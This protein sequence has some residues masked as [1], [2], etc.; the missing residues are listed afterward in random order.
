MGYHDKS[1][2][3]LCFLVKPFAIISL[4]TAFSVLALMQTADQAHAAPTFIGSS[5]IFEVSQEGRFR[6]SAPA[7][8]RDK[9]AKRFYDYRSASSH[10]GFE[11]AGRSIVFLYRDVR[12]DDLALFLTHG[13][14]DMGQPRSQRQGNARVN[15]SVVGVPAGARIAE[16]D[17]GPHEFDWGSAPNAAPGTANGPPIAIGKW[18]YGNNTDGG[19]I[20]L[21]PPDQ[22]WRIE[23]NINLVHGMDDWSYF[24]ADGTRQ[25]L[26]PSLPLI[27]E[28]RGGSQ[29]PDQVASVEGQEVTVCALASDDTGSALS[30]R[31]SWRDG[32]QSNVSLPSGQL[33]C[34]QHT[35]LDDGH[36]EIGIRVTNNR[37]QSA[38]KV[39]TADIANVV[40]TLI[41]GGPYIVDE[42][43]PLTLQLDS[44]LDPGALDTHQTRWDFDGDG[45][46]DTPFRDGLS[47]QAIY[48]TPGRYFARVQARDD[49]GGV[50]SEVIT[51]YAGVPA[52]VFALETNPNIVI[53]GYSPTNPNVPMPVYRGAPITLKAILRNTKLCDSYQV[54]WD[55]DED[56]LF[57]ENGDDQVLNDLRPEF[58]S[59]YDAGVTYQVPLDAAEGRRLIAMRARNNCND[60]VDYDV[61]RL[62]VYPW[63]P[64]P[65][66]LLWTKEQ[67]EVM[68]Q[69][70]LQ[71]ALWFMHRHQGNRGGG[72]A[73]IYSRLEANNTTRSDPATAL[74]IWAYTINGRLPAYPPNTIEV[75]PTGIGHSLPQ[76][77]EEE[78]LIRWRLDPYSETV[79]R[80]LNYIVSTSAGEVN[81]TSEDEDNTCELSGVRCERLSSSRPGKGAYINGGNNSSYNHGVSTGAIGT[82]LPAL[83]GTPVQVGPHRGQLWEGLV[84]DMVDYLGYLQIPNGCGRGG[85]YYNR[86]TDTGCGAM[87]A[88]T[89][90]WG[91]IGLE[92]AEVAGFR[93][94]VFV[95]TRHKYRTAH[96]VVRNQK[97]NGAASYRTDGSWSGN[98]LQ[99]TGGHFVIARWLGF[100]RF[101]DAPDPQSAP[102]SSVGVSYTK[103]QMASMLTK[104]RDFTANRW[105]STSAGDYH[106]Q[107]RFWRNGDYLC[108]RATG[109]YRWGTD[110]ACGNLYG[111]YSHQKGYRTTFKEYDR[112]LGVVQEGPAEGKIGSYDW[113]RQFATYV[114]RSQLRD[115]GDYGQFGRIDDSGSGTSISWDYG[116]YNLGVT[117]GTLVLTPTIFKPRPVADG[118]VTP[119]QVLEGCSGPDA[120][121]V[122][123]EHAGSFHPNPKSKIERFQWDVDLADR[124]WWDGAGAGPRY[125]VERIYESESAE[126][127]DGFKKIFRHK[128]ERA[129]EYVVTLRVED[130]ENQAHLKNF[131]VNV[132]A[133]QPV[134]PTVNHRGPYLLTEGQA[135][136]LNGVANDLNYDC[137][138]T[139]N[140]SWSIDGGGAPVPRELRDAISALNKASLTEAE[141]LPASLLAGLRPEHSYTLTLRAEDSTGRVAT[142][143]TELIIYPREPVAALSATPLRA[144]CDQVVRFDASESAHPHP[145]IEIE[146]YEWDLDGLPGYE[147]QGALSSVDLSYPRFGTYPARVKVSATNQEE[148]VSSTIEVVVDQGNQAPVASLPE[149]EVVVLLGDGLRVNGA[150]SYDPDSGCGDEIVA[151]RWYV[152]PSDEQS[153]PQF[154]TL[155]GALELSAS[156]VSALL[157]GPADPRTGEPANRLVLEVEDSLGLKSR[158]ELRVT[159]YRKEPVAHFDQLPSPAPINDESGEVVVKLDARESF[160]PRPGGAVINYRWDTNGDGV[161][162][163]FVGQSVLTFR[164]LFEPAPTPDN[165]PTVEVGVQV[166]DERG[167]VGEYRALL[168]YKVGAVEP[169]A[170]ADPSDA[171][172]Q[173][174]H[175]LFGDSLSLNGAQS[176]EPNDGDWIRYY[177]WWVNSTPGPRGGDWQLEELDENGDAL[178]AVVLVPPEQLAEWGVDSVGVYPIHFEAEDSTFLTARDETTL[179]VHEA[180]PVPLI[181][182]PRSQLS[183]G[184][185]VALDGG[186]SAHAHP[187]IDIIRWEWDLDGDGEFGGPEDAEGER[188]VLTAGRFTFLEPLRVSLRVTDS[189]GHQAVD[190]VFLSV[191]QGNSAPVADAGGP[192]AV[193]LQD[194]LI[195]LDATRTVDLEASCGDAI[196]RY[197]WDLDGDGLY[198]AS[199]LELRLSG[200]SAP[201][202]TKEELQSLL[203]PS[204]PLGLYEVG[205]EVEDRW[206]LTARS[207]V[208]LSVFHGPTAVATAE[209]PRATCDT[210]VR[211]SALSSSSDGPLDRGFRITRYEWDFDQDGEIDSTEPVTIYRVG[212]GGADVEARLWVYDEA[213][214]VSDARVTFE[215]SAENNVPPVADAG[216]PYSTGALNAAQMM[217]ITLDGRAS[218]D[219]DAPCDAIVTYK[220]DTDND[221]LFG[222]DDTNGAGSRAGSDYEGAVIQGFVDPTWEIG[223]SKLVRLIVCDSKGACSPPVA[224]EVTVLSS[225]PP[226]GE[227]LSPRSQQCQALE[228]S[229]PIRLRYRDPNGGIVRTRVFIDDVEVLYQALSAPQD[230]SDVEQVISVDISDLPDGR[231][232]LRVELS[233]LQGALTALSPGGPVVF[234]RE[235]PHIELNARLL[236]GA[237]Y[238]PHQVPDPAPVVIDNLD[239]TPST[240]VSLSDEACVKTMTVTATDE[241]GNRAELQ[242]SYRVAGPV[243]LVIEGP[244]EGGLISQ[245]EARLSWTYPGPQSCVNSVVSRLSVAGGPA[246]IY[247]AGTLIEDSGEVLLSLDAQDCA[248]ESYLS[249]RSFR[250]NSPPIAIPITLGHPNAVP[251]EQVPTYRVSEGSPLI[252]NAGDSRAPESQDRVN[253]Y[254]WDLDGDGLFE[255]DG[256][257][258][259]L[260][261]DTSEDGHF[262]GTL[263]VE[264][265][266]GARHQAR[267]DVKVDD[268][269]PVLSLGG[270]YQGLQGQE[271]IFD[272]SESR[273]HNASD[274]LSGA[275][276]DWGDGQQSEGLVATHRFEHDGLYEV[277]LTVR[278]EDSAQ[279]AF[280]QVSVADVRPII[281][282]VTSPAEAYTLEDLSFVVEASP[283]ASGDQIVSYDWDFMGSGHFEAFP[284]PEA[285][286][287]YPEPGQYRPRLR[288]RDQD[289][290]TEHELEIN[291]R[292]VTLSDLLRELEREIT[293]SLNDPNLSPSARAALAPQGQLS[294]LEWVARGLWAEEQRVEALSVGVEGG[295]QP[296]DPRLGIATLNERLATLY[297][298]N[299]L[300]AFDELLF[301]LNRAQAAGARYGGLMWKLS[302]ELLRATEGLYSE[303]LA[304]LS[305]LPEVIAELDPRLIAASTQLEHARSIFENVDFLDRVTGRDGY[306]ARDLLAALLEAHFLLRDVSDISYQADEFYLVSTGGAAFRVERGKLV[307]Q[308]L[309]VAVEQLQAELE[310]YIAAAQASGGP[311]LEAVE[312]ALVALSDIHAWVSQPIGLRCLNEDPEAEEC[313]WI[314]DRDSLSLQLALMDL[315]GDLFAAANEGVYVRNAQQMLILGVK[316]RVEVALLRIEALCGVTSPY[317]ISARAQQSVMLTLLGEGQRDAA[318]LYYIA[319]ERRCLVYQL[320]NECVVPVLN[321][322]ANTPEELRESVEYPPLCDSVELVGQTSGAGGVVSLEPPIPPRPPFTELQLLREIIEAFLRPLNVASTQVREAHYPGRSWADFNRYYSDNAFT[323]DDVDMAI[324][325]FTHDMIDFD[326]D[327]LI[328]LYE[329]ECQVRYGVPL[330]PVNPQSLNLPD[331]ELDCDGDGIPNAQELQLSLNPVEAADA[332][333]DSDGDGMSN[334]QEWLWSTRGLELDLRDPS[335]G[336]ADHDGDGLSNSLEL[337]GGLDPSNPSDAGADFDQDGLSNGLELS[338]GLNPR[339]AEDADLDQDDDGLSAREEVLR[340]RDPFTLDCESDLIELSGR[341]D[342]AS[343]ARALATSQEG[344]ICS[345]RARE[346]TDWYRLD[347]EREGQRFVASARALDLELSDL[348]LT[349]FSEQ[350][351]QVASSQDAYPIALIAL[352]RGQL[353]PGTYYLRVSHGAGDRAPEFRYLLEHSLIDPDAP[354]LPDPWE[355]PQGNHQRG[356]AR[357]LGAQLVR[358]GD[359]WVCEEERNTG[360]WYSIELDG[361]DR[362]VH[363]SFS[364]SSDGQLNLAVMDQELTRYEESV[365]LQKSAQ[366]INIRANGQQGTLYIRVTAATIYADGDERVDYALQVV[367]TALDERP[368]G[369]CDELNHGL[370]D[371]H[372]WPTLDY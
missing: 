331:G 25:I 251:L 274:P 80:M 279:S 349:L 100:D 105:R 15:G 71:E 305:A 2:P 122:E 297:R 208:P 159:M 188:A 30:Y 46:W 56:G 10:T 222:A 199:P 310:C 132:S 204:D 245:S 16:R 228:D 296:I 195:H 12:N 239:N 276:W 177:R 354:C 83:S 151:Y 258:P 206:G 51:V 21:L 109:L 335:D 180:Q 262:E 157:R 218:F 28:S 126:P 123:L 275:T 5:R 311:G 102:F 184:E 332:E 224:Q 108:G 44:I 14:D 162:S 309:I 322:Q 115:L 185:Q 352:S 280:V 290:F 263:E 295:E 103:S 146:R 255:R 271:L 173:G 74:A 223:L 167:E 240:L 346:D 75:D 351:A 93:Y 340:G 214:R 13:I 156:Q 344:V 96:S 190:E 79:T 112:A 270:P 337:R 42:Q 334:Y 319:P 97:S 154:S 244:N 43:T 196:V 18:H 176:L 24:F 330:D 248:G 284:S 242:R 77:W 343:R 227:I 299:S 321:A 55:T 272:A 95:N 365:A 252:L 372:S 348:H 266:F 314:D 81:V 161:Y 143:S 174:Y 308:D 86:T 169:T 67:L 110:A 147:R 49:D 165:V 368:R 121:W 45:T 264:D 288:V 119:L 241:C 54:I 359:A 106:G 85:W 363:V 221:N 9:S 181:K 134:D 200:D 179:T 41:P 355:G 149:R 281:L 57:E 116:S 278:D 341:D 230:G 27:I 64:D 82:I 226:T 128:F 47:A 72:G 142:A 175:I 315:V 246:R 90:Q 92:S 313:Q 178:E 216:G 36:Y 40:P 265:S 61:M 20:D 238:A 205:L 120:G 289:S 261:F 150:G 325:Q 141:A 60:F 7:V 225:P 125:E 66:P 336:L 171:P 268:V 170:D 164:Q 257:S 32:S 113:E 38:E 31:F 247:Q 166:T 1:N 356:L 350:G 152:N 153:S 302:R 219:P 328:G 273:A 139:L 192:Y 172:E 88:S 358:I 201:V 163:E 53:A 155:D 301:R 118:S 111:I 207:R 269:Q 293:Q 286:F 338:F 371:F 362:T 267:F 37:N 253:H 101:Q 70:G 62:Y 136:R 347:V 137:D 317:P 364:P 361:R 140:V 256:L 182:L 307:N 370:Y 243:E 327:G 217:G 283:G 300:Q 138:P 69:V 249:Q 220:W 124:Y 133:M 329:L 160:S 259:S 292:E 320:Y 235:P 306:L 209:P 52:D 34:A 202:L 324:K 23:V 323:I 94:G 287:R 232:Q 187:Q 39:F 237:C 84:Q 213:G 158:T 91:Y 194:E 130:D 78:N 282:S 8:E 114:L 260:S 233:D 318:L 107:N 148:S 277:E 89:A 326:D 6:K 48:E 63:T 19:A 294:S 366:C 59:V 215:V 193:G 17:D 33:A 129:G 131:W 360:D 303:E 231:H 250:V 98:N 186:G 198:G 117:M 87:D 353:S 68:T 135:L 104:A 285:Q 369:A 367:E 65:N 234:D 3:Y 210:D 50:G 339:S 189:R 211:F 26:D 312:R 144:Q 203:D 191:N 183:C 22:D 99:L 342:D 345:T 4:A 236:E 73:Q 229:L 127:L 291:V 254:R 357:A 145:L 298:G 333:L 11:V 29:E 35:Y 212:L 316:F 168:N 197:D 76:G 304:R 58:N